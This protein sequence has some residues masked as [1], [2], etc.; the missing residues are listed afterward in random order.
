MVCYQLCGYC[1]FFLH[2]LYLTC[3]TQFFNVL[4]TVEAVVMDGGCGLLRLSSLSFGTCTLNFFTWE[5]PHAAFSP[6]GSGIADPT[7]WL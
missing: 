1:Y 2:V 5:A 6:F 7:L 3:T 4:G